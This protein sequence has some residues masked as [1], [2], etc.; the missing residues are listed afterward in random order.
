VPRVS[1]VE[2]EPTPKEACKKELIE[3]GGG[4][5]TRLLREFC[6]GVHVPDQGVVTLVA[7]LIAN[8]FRFSVRSVA[9][10]TAQAI[11][12]VVRFAEI[13]LAVGYDLKRGK[14][15]EIA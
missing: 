1:G 10:V 9:L 15:G 8:C 4:E 11:P 13:L 14:P 5:N 2:T 12:A 7:A 6:F 3:P